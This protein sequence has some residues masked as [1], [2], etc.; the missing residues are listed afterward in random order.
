MVAPLLALSVSVVVVMPV[1]ALTELM[2][3][4]IAPSPLSSIV[5]VIVR[6][7]AVASV[8]ILERSDRLAFA[9]LSVIRVL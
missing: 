7:S 5:V 6:L 1:K 2:V 3:R 8:T 9:S 4:S